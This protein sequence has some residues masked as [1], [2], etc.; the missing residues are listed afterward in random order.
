MTETNRAILIAASILAAAY[1]LTHIHS[2]DT[3]EKGSAYV[4]NNITGTTYYCWG[5][6][7]KLETSAPKAP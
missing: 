3:T 7:E 6:C 1:F 4:M 5:T 2:I